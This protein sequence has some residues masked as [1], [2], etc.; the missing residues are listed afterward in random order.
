MPL[1]GPRPTRTIGS[2]RGEP[3]IW[4]QPVTRAARMSWICAR[5]MAG[6]GLARLVTT[7]TPLSATGVSTRSGG[8]PGIRFRATMPASLIPRSA[9]AIPL[10][11]T[12]P[13]SVKRGGSLTAWR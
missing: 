4:L 10:W 2:V 7:H 5:V 13:T 3:G 9:S 11:L 8:S 1:V 12:P 6:T